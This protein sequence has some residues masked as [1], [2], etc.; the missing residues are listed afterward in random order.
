MKPFVSFVKIVH[1]PDFVEAGIRDIF[2]TLLIHGIPFY[3]DSKDSSRYEDHEVDIYV[4]ISH[5]GTIFTKH[6][7][8]DYS[9]SYT[10]RNCLEYIKS[11]IPSL[12]RDFIGREYPSRHHKLNAI[13]FKMFIDSIHMGRTMQ[14]MDTISIFERYDGD[15]DQAFAFIINSL[16]RDACTISTPFAIIDYA[17]DVDSTILTF[18]V[19]GDLK[20]SDIMASPMFED[21]EV[22]SESNTECLNR[23]THF[24][25]RVRYN[26]KPNNHIDLGDEVIF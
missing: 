14:S 11:Y 10:I 24:V 15:E 8:V 6:F 4:D 3:L 20:I 12:I 26:P 1:G 5:M 25:R 21:Y 16:L 9:E 22:I 18:Y 19:V 17:R 23:V 7:V 2:E 13:Y